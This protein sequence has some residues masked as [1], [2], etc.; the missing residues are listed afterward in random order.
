MTDEELRLAEENGPPPEIGSQVTEMTQPVAAAFTVKGKEASHR[1]PL[2]NPAVKKILIAVVILGVALVGLKM[3]LPKGAAAEHVGLTFKVGDQHRYRMFVTASGTRTLPP[4]GKTQSVSMNMSATIDML[5]TAT[6]NEGADVDVTVSNFALHTGT[7]TL[8][9][10]PRVIHAKVRI[11]NDGRVVSG[12][13]GLSAALTSKMMPGWDLFSPVLADGS[14][15]PGD[16]WKTS[17]SVA[18]VG[19]NTVQVTGDSTLLSYLNRDGDRVGV[20][21]SKITYPYSGELSMQEIADSLGVGIDQVGFPEGSDPKFTYEGTT[22]LDMTAQINVTKGVLTGSRAAGQTDYT[23]SVAGWPK[24]MGEAPKSNAQ[25]SLTFS[26]NLK[27]MPLPTAEEEAS[28]S[29]GADAG[30]G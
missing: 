27:T 28:P 13:L 7:P 12:G 29:A 11:D 19:D 15:I 21:S 4:K 8:D 23:V 30:Q 18:F 17:D 24:S 14:L 26:V 2:D 10:S 22:T 6:D 9:Q 25:T 5:V 16:T 3:F 1:T 20:V